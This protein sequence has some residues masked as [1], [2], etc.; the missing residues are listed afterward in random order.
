M[1]TPSRSLPPATASSPERRTRRGLAIEV[2][3]RPVRAVK[4]AR[5]YG[6]DSVI[7][8]S[9]CGEYLRGIYSSHVNRAAAWMFGGALRAPSP[10]HSDRLRGGWGNVALGISYW[11]AMDTAVVLVG[12]RAASYEERNLSFVCFFFSVFSFFPPSP[13]RTPSHWRCAGLGLGVY[14]PRRDTTREAERH[15][16]WRL[17]QH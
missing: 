11:R 17:E 12:I 14:F 4:G 1:Q 6:N 13:G 15:H 8:P 9:F 3:H 10:L 16:L 7:D 5:R 2:Q